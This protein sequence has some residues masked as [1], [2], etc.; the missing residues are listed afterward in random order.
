MIYREIKN[1]QN[2]PESRLTP[3]SQAVL[4]LLTL[5]ICKNI[6]NREENETIQNLNK[7]LRTSQ[8]RRKFQ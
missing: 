6:E 1:N 2:M 5:F 7:K 3:L 4:H 8:L